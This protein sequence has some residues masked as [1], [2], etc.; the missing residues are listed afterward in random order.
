[1]Y[2]PYRKILT[3]IF[4]FFI[5][6]QLYSQNYL[7]PT[8][9]S[10]FV[11][12]SF[13]E[14]REGHYHAAID[15]K[16]WLREGFPCYAVEDGYIERIRL[17]PFGYGKVVYLKLKDGNTAVYAHLQKF[18]KPVEAAVRRQQL[19]N[20]HYSI[21]WKPDTLLVHKGDIIAYTGGTGAGPP[22]L[23][24]EIRN[25]AGNPVNP[26]HFYPQH[27]D[28]L[29]PG[30][31]SLICIP[32]SS[33]AMINGSYLP[34]KFRLTYSKDGFY[35]LS[36]PIRVHGRIGLGIKGFDQAVE[37]G[38]SFGFYETLMMINTDTVYQ[39]RY[40]ELNFAET[41]YIYTEI[42]YPAW[43]ESG[44][45]FHKLYIEDYNRLNIYRQNGLQSGII[46][47]NNEPVPITIL[48]RDIRFN[49]SMIKMEL[50]PDSTED[51]WV[52]DIRREGEWTYLTLF[53]DPFRELVFNTGKSTNSLKPVTYFEIIE[54]KVRDPRQ[55]IRIK[56]NVGDSSNTLLKVVLKTSNRLFGQ[57][58]SIAMD[59]IKALKR[60]PE[61]H[62]LGSDLVLRFNDF[63]MPGML[64][65]ASSTFAFPLKKSNNRQSE[66][67]IPGNSITDGNHTF[68]LYTS[69]VPIWS[70]DIPLYRLYPGRKKTFSW[71]DSAFVL[72]T[73]K[74]SVLD[75]VLIS[76]DSLAPDVVK[77]VLPLA[78]PVY[79]IIP[80]N[81]P[82]FENVSIRIKADSLAS[83]GNWAIYQIDRP[84]KI[85]FLSTQIDSENMTLTATT[86]SFGRFMVASDTIP[87]VLEI[88]SPQN[89]QTYTKNPTIK[90]KLDDP[91]SG[92]EDE[93]NIFVLMDGWF[94]LPEWDPEK[95]LVRAGYDTA[96]DPGAHTLT[97]S[98]KDQSG[99]IRRKA[100][101]FTITN[102]L[103]KQ[104][105]TRLPL[106]G[107]SSID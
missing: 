101:F 36:E 12:S 66:V 29:R 44:E 11:S 65:S 77:N 9:A 67:L 21:D 69:P 90:F 57:T 38:N 39:I 92:I 6:G 14:F 54:G 72:T 5:S 60:E 25:Q 28:D 53:S 104:Q 95:K 63:T 70:R 20:Q 46:Q 88:I 82:V 37:L 26:L 59:N 50:L 27:K 48:V 102:L 52:R 33:G 78:S 80:Q 87:P 15:I 84:D 97:V 93:Q 99:N 86:S 41:A 19:E 16:T 2:K 56:I 68:E 8:N 85:S 64:E 30:L 34:Q 47:M 43:I 74:E 58:Y 24:F 105:G 71:Y 81:F 83:W 98:V 40:D 76:V 107:S 32:H 79:Q 22:H 75:T 17:S 100:V 18:S 10:N 103:K 61:Y 45:V 62:F 23:H 35:K 4:F 31:K 3:L 49:Q 7:W 13:C 89:G 94:V 42:Y 106:P 91:Q 51:L 55:G 96:L 73:G 1:M